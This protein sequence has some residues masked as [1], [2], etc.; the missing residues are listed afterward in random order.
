MIQRTCRGEVDPATGEPV[1]AEPLATPAKGVVFRATKQEGF[2]APRRRQYTAHG[3]GAK[4]ATMPRGTWNRDKGHGDKKVRPPPRGR[5][6]G[7]R[8]KE[9]SKVPSGG[10]LKVML[11]RSR[12]RAPE[13]ENAPLQDVSDVV[14]ACVQGRTSRCNQKQT[15][16][17]STPAG[18]SNPFAKINAARNPPFCQNIFETPV[19]SDESGGLGNSC[20]LAGRTGTDAWSRLSTFSNFVT[21]ESGGGVVVYDVDEETTGTNDIVGT[22]QRTKGS[23]RGT[24]SA[25]PP[26]VMIKKKRSLPTLTLEGSGKDRKKK[27]KALPRSLGKGKTLLS[28]FGRSAD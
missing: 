8:V 13:K 23:S 10:L 3:A 19:V 25:V 21:G 20:L 14:L 28:Y 17:A 1:T 18:T 9:S 11:E 7:E 2:S 22:A 26:A 16:E 5:G 12:S 24:P 4:S 15:P 6:A 27:A